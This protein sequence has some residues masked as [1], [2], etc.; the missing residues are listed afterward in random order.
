MRK[1]HGLN[2]RRYD[3]RLVDLTEY[4]STFPGE[5]ASKKIAET[6]LNDMF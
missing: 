3:D 1:P 4:L 6:K 5:N 2:L